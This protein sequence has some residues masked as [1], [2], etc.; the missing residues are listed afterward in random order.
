MP[1]LRYVVLQHSEIDEP[2][3]DLM[4]ETAPGSDLATWRVSH[5]PPDATDKFTALP[6]HRRHYLEYEGPI[7]G[8]RGKVLRIA[9]GTHQIVENSPARFVIHLDNGNQIELTRTA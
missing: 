1:A 6:N 3:Y 7:S 8:N 9:S 2:H 5:W 4:I